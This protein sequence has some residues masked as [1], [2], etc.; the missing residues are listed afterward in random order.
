MRH[1]LVVKATETVWIQVVIDKRQPFDVTLKQGETVAWEAAEALTLKIGNA[2][3][4]SLSFNGKQMAPVGKLGY[5]V[6]LD[7]P[8]GKVKVLSGPTKAEE[9]P[10]PRPEPA[11]GVGIKELLPQTA[12]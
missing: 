1:S 4:V 8:G 11:P 5:V 9:G 2:G 10:A 12:P 3:G 6:S 7:L